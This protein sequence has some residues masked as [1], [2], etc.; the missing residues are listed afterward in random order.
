MRTARRSH[1]NGHKRIFLP[2]P[3]RAQV[4]Q[5]CV[6]DGTGTVSTMHTVTTMYVRDENLLI[7]IVHQV[8]VPVQ[9]CIQSQA[10]LQKDRLTTTN[11][12]LYT[13]AT[14]ETTDQRHYC[15]KVGNV[16][17]PFLTSLL[18]QS[19]KS[20]SHKQQIQKYPNEPRNNTNLELFLKSYYY[21]VFGFFFDS[22]RLKPFL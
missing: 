8:P 4:P 10:C 13:K 19:S 15:D 6:R 17:I 22:P 5:Q 21:V 18:S 7:S 11:T 1:N 9:Q 12:L 16:E 2:V 20:F 3:V 14:V